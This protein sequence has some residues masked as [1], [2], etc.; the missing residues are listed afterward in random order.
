MVTTKNICADC[1]KKAPPH[2]RSSNSICC[3]C[4]LYW[5][6]NKLWYLVTKNSPCKQLCLFCLRQRAGRDLKRSDF[7][8]LHIMVNTRESP[9]EVVK[10]MVTYANSGVNDSEIW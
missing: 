2:V 1:G 4:F 10:R 9:K 3:H 5:T 8:K 6:T 7:E